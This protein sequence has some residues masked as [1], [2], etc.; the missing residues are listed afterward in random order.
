MKKKHIIFPSAVIIMVGHICIL[1]FIYI[2]LANPTPDQKQD[3][4]M[5]VAPLTAAYFITITKFVIDN[6]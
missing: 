6:A 5:L 2:Y 4:A 1:P 3:L